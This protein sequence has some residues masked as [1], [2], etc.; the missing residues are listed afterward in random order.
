MVEVRSPEN[1]VV[2]RS[3][4]SVRADFDEAFTV[5]CFL[6]RL[7]LWPCSSSEEYSDSS[8]ATSG[9]RLRMFALGPRFLNMRGFSLDRDFCFVSASAIFEQDSSD[10]DLVVSFMRGESQMCCLRPIGV[11]QRQR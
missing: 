3:L 5:P 10:V 2:S 8:E 7:I 6:R 9:G 4:R 11:S 1:L